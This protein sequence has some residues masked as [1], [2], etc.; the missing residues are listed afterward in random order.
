MGNEISHYI[1]RHTMTVTMIVVLV[2][3]ALAGGEYLLY[4][5]QMVLNKMISEGFMQLK[6]LQVVLPNTST[7]SA[8]PKVVR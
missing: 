1:R 2:F 8:L 7:G 5:N 3:L 4:R 6:E